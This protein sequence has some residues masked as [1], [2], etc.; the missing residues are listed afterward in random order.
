MHF[1]LALVA[2]A[3][4]FVTGHPGEHHEG[5]TAKL[6]SARQDHHLSVRRGLESCANH[7]SFRALKE[8]AIA[9]R[10]DTVTAHRKSKRASA[11]GVG[12]NLTDSRS[13]I[14]IDSS[15]ETVF[16]SN[17]TCILNPEGEIGPYYVKGELIRNNVRDDEP[18]VPIVIEGQFIDVETCEPLT[19][20]YWD[21]WNCN[22]TGV[23]SG[24]VAEGNGNTA[25]T[26]NLNAT[27]LRGIQKTDDE[28]VVQFL[29][30]FPGHYEGRATHHH[31]VAWINATMLPNNTI[32]SG[33]VAHIGQLFWDQ[34]LINEV[35]A[36]YPYNLNNIS[37]TE[38][39]DDRVV[40][41]E[42]SDTTSD[43]F[44]NYVYL[45]EDLDDGLFGWVTI[46]VN[47]SASYEPTYSYT[48]GANGG[49]EVS[50]DSDS[51]SPQGT[52]GGFSQGTPGGFPEGTSTDSAGTSTDSAGTSTSSAGTSTDSAGASTDAPEGAAVGCH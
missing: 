7:P 4:P 41:G 24:L 12:H 48:Y 34:D 51:G 2:I 22:S 29:S 49:T 23:Y 8:R 35:E 28:G 26:S 19:D 11:T 21:I 27:F 9:R 3:A 38:N 16:G 1:S 13:D 31:M 17:H 36:T 46:G 42:V 52:P 18:G 10:F 33:Y 15:D 45:G 37:I 44:F 30:V 20:L 14:A 50:G 47:T 5:A 43:P 6:L 25:D 32:T 39:A 40:S